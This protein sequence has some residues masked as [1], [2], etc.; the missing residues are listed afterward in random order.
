[1]ALFKRQ[2]L[3]TGFPN[4][5]VS[6]VWSETTPNIPKPRLLTQKISVYFSYFYT[7]CNSALA[8]YN[9]R[10][11]QTV[12]HKKSGIMGACK[13]DCYLDCSTSQ[14]SDPF[15]RPPEVNLPSGR[16]FILW[17]P[18][19]QALTQKPGDIKILRCGSR[20]SLHEQLIS[21]SCLV[22]TFPGFTL[23]SWVAST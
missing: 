1:M 17:L 12:I 23:C 10:L 13:I 22:V 20:V 6:R 14:F 16:S 7:T 2:T 19:L 3:L 18:G 8:D 5:D 11:D 9:Q 4:W 15:G 21:H